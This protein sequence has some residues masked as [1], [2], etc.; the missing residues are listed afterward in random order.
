MEQ[1]QLD[2]LQDWF[3]DYVAGFY[4]DDEYINANLKLKEDHTRRVCREIWYIADRLGLPGC[5]KRVAEAIAL[6]HDIGRFEQFARFRT[7]FDMASIRHSIL[8]VQILRQN[9]VLQSLDE[10]E[11]EWIIKAVEYHADKQLPED[12]NGSCLLFAQ[13]IRDADKLDIYNVITRYYERSKNNPQNSSLELGLPDRPECSP[14]IIEKMHRGESIDFT[15]LRT[16]NDL[17][18]MQLGWL[19][20]INFTVTL[21]QIKARRYLE[22]LVGFLPITADIEMIAQRLFSYIDERLR[23][24]NETKKSDCSAFRASRNS[25]KKKR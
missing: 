5:Q 17:K 20:D 4:G 1:R 12:L 19:H 3:D 6:F 16:L 9:G 25:D 22:A 23:R 11:R 18:L 24:S 7:Y 10:C 15:E 21:E 14:R 2:E 13:L 8:G